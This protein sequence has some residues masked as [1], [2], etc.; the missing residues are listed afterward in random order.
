MLL[1]DIVILSAHIHNNKRDIPEADVSS[2]SFT[3][4]LRAL[5]VLF[6]VEYKFIK[7]LSWFVF[8]FKK[9]KMKNKCC[10]LFILVLC[11]QFDQPCVTMINTYCTSTISQWITLHVIHRRSACNVGLF[12]GKCSV[13]LHFRNLHR[14]CRVFEKK[15]K[16][17][18][19][20]IWETANW[21]LKTPRLAL[22]V[23][24]YY[25]WQSC[26]YWEWFGHASII[27]KGGVYHFSG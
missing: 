15:K 14:Y 9:K 23:R 16:N 7:L 21:A 25:Q 20:E 2:T 1:F 5:P 6:N 10:S 24:H 22:Y 26:Y 3:L 27:L 18:P 4:I 19:F 11:Y 12:S 17:Q 13:G 8:L